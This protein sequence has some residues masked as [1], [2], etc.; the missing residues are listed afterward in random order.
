MV[1]SY[2]LPIGNRTLGIRWSH[3]RWRHVTRKVKVVTPIHLNLNIS[4]TVRDRRSVLLLTTYRKHYI[5]NPLVTWLMTS[6]DPKRSTSWPS[7]LWSLISQ[8]PCEMAGQQP[9]LH[10][11]VP[12]IVRIHGVLKVKVKVKGHV[13]RALLWCYEM[14]AIQYLLTFCLYMHS[15]YEIPL[16][17]PSTISVRQP[18]VMSTSWNE[19]LRRFRCVRSPLTWYINFSFVHLQ[20]ITSYVCS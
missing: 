4:I 17:C 19:L 7:Y 9:N 1:G 13:I 10:T 6:R 2:R 5:A 3:D 16:H 18:H 20:C 12:R 14:F 15:L 8:Q 11:M